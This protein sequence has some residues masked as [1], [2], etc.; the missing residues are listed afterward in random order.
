MEEEEF[1]LEKIIEEG[2]ERDKRLAKMEEDGTNDIVKYFDRIHDKLFDLNNILIAGYF[3][4]VALNKQVSKGIIFVPLINLSFLIYVEW[5]M[6]EK[7]RL[8]SQITK[9]SGADREKYGAMIASTNLYSLGVIVTTL[10]VTVVLCI[11]LYNL[12]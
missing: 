4:L 10:I 12:G 5:R 7:S 11:V 9:V 6:M 8:Q 1:D 2:E 3:A